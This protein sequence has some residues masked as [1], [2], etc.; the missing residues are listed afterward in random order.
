M[1]KWLFVVLFC[2]LIIQYLDISIV[3]CQ[4]MIVYF[5]PPSAGA[6]A[7][8]GKAVP[9]SVHEM[10]CAVSASVHTSVDPSVHA[11]TWFWLPGPHVGSS[12]VATQSPSFVQSPS[13]FSSTQSGR[14]HPMV[15]AVSAAVHTSVDPSVHVLTWL[16]V[17]A[18]HVGLSS[19]PTQS[20]S[21][22]QSPSTFSTTQS[23]RAVPASL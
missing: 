1:I 9:A 10:D 15:C 18:P 23:G 19:V 20:P 16:W 5:F 17:P 22:V 14:A 2:D 8:S 4:N 21:F 7:H 3:K 13:T 12:P 11:L 6:A